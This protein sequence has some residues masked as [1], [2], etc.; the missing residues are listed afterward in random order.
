[1][2]FIVVCFQRIEIRLSPL[3]N[4]IIPPFFIFGA[5][6]FYYKVMFVCANNIKMLVAHTVKVA[7]K[8][9]PYY[10]IDGF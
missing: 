5:I 10:L 6:V 9:S 1:M 2:P 3:R 7:D 4:F 8:S